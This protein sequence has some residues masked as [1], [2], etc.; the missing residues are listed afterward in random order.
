[1]LVGWCNTDTVEDLFGWDEVAAAYAGRFSDELDA[2]PF[3]RKLLDWLVERADPIGPICDLGCG[4]GQVAA[5]VHARGGETC[6]IDLSQKM[7]QHAAT[8]NPDISFQV[9]D[10][11]DLADVETGAFGG[12]ASFYSIVNL[13]H[14]DHARVFA[15]MRR[16]LRPGGWLLLS[17][18]IGDEVRHVEQFLG[19]RVRLDFHFFRPED[20]RSRLQSV[21]LDVVE[22]I[23]RGPYPEPVEAQTDRAYLFATTQPEDRSRVSG[24]TTRP[25]ESPGR[26]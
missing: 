3:D 24:E 15:E 11:C 17:F 8:S 12:I 7:V 2:K 21:G 9:G 6:G 26:R 4:P 18:H 10:M 16:T 13:P 20:V 19:E 1:M 5:Y 22:A 14:T 25:D 23:Q